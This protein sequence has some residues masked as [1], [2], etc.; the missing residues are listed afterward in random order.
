MS[1][2][3]QHPQ[4]PIADLIA[5]R[6]SP[7]NFDENR[8]VEPEKLTSCLEAARWA[9]S[10][11]NEQPWRF[12]I[13]DRFHTPAAWQQLIEGMPEGNR[14]WAEKAPVLVLLSSK[15]HFTHHG[16][17]NRWAAYDAGQAAL[18]FSLQATALGLAT[19]QIGGFDAAKAREDFS[20]PEEF[21]PLAVIVLGYT[22]TPQSNTEAISTP[23]TRKT[24]SEIAFWGQWGAPFKPPA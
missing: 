22:S 4:A 8:P 17:P 11:Y 5:R 2:E 1:Q 15:L 12:L 10:C 24:L 14:T 13:T 9:P 7:R 23:R 18:A 19:H 3:R 6:W 16:K 20:I 21:E